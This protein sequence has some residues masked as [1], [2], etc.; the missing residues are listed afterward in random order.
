MITI[1]QAMNAK[2]DGF[3]VRNGQ[4]NTGDF[5]HPNGGNPINTKVLEEI[6]K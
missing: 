2:P 6:M 3:G 4:P 5:N 1:A